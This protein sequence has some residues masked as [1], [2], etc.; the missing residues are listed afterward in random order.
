M[1]HPCCDAIVT[2]EK[3]P[4]WGQEGLHNAVSRSLQLKVGCRWR[5]FQEAR[6]GDGTHGANLPAAAQPAECSFLSCPGDHMQLGVLQTFVGLPCSWCVRP[7][8][9]RRPRRQRSAANCSPGWERVMQGIHI[10]PVLHCSAQQ[11]QG[12]SAG[13]RTRQHPCSAQCH[14]QQPPAA[15]EAAVPRRLAPAGHLHSLKLIGQSR[16]ELPSPLAE[17]RTLLCRSPV[18]GPPA[19]AQCGNHER[20]QVQCNAQVLSLHLSAQNA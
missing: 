11:M 4:N 6:S 9:G 13:F 14:T 18:V 19:S 17:Q 8:A 1:L 7:T 15:V 5:R 16:K 3:V 20:F 12:W 10:G 2:P